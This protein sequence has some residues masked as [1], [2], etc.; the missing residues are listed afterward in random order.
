MSGPE[1]AVGS[2][3]GREEHDPARRDD[4][5]RPLVERL[6]VRAGQLDEGGRAARVVVRAGSGPEVDGP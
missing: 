2:A 6:G 4:V 1:P 3:V 5:C